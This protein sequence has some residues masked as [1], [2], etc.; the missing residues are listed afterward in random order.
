MGLNNRIQLARDALKI[1]I[2]S[3]PVDCKFTI[4]SFGHNYE[5]MKG[6]DAQTTF[7]YSD[8]TKEFAI[9]KIE[10]F[11]ADMGGTDIYRPLSKAQTGFGSDLKKRIFLLTDGAVD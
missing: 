11:K 6:V 8:E 7:K 4:I 2:Q 5:V 1:F 3:L 9:R 10:D